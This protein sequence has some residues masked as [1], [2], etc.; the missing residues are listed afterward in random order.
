MAK[1]IFHARSSA[2]KFGGKYTDYLKI[3]D[4][5]DEPKAHHATMKFRTIFHSAY[6]IFLVEKILGHEFT[7][8]DGRIVSVRAVA[9]QHIM[10]DLGFIPSLDEY[11][12]EMQE[13]PWMAGMKKATLVNVD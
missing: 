13:K 8:S 10:E 4:Q 11:L 1:P 9:E 5:I 3:H 12:K 7:N 2:R 6:G